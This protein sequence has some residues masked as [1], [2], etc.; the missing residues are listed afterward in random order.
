MHN[1]PSLLLC[2]YP[3]YP[4]GDGASTGC[5]P[6]LDAEDNEQRVGPV[7][8]AVRQPYGYGPHP[9]D[10]GAAVRAGGEGERGGIEGSSRE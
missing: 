2:P 5:G 8:Q 6:G 7:H 9:H 1:P 10:P 4:A 3:C